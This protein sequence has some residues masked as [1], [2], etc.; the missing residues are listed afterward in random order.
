MSNVTITE[1]IPDDLPD[2]AIEAMA[3]GR[4]FH[5]MCE[6]AKQVDGLESALEISEKK[7]AVLTGMLDIDVLNKRIAELE[8]I[9]AIARS[10]EYEGWM[11]GNSDY[12][13]SLA[14]YIN[15]KFP[16]PTK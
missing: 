10:F 13:R 15:E 3:D 11:G 16:K 8:Q 12:I 7:V 4:L 9:E 6:K 14:E 2:W 5:V 1:T